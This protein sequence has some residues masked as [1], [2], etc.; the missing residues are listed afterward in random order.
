MVQ[1]LAHEHLHV[2]KVIDPVQGH[3]VVRDRLDQDQLVVRI[4]VERQVIAQVAAHRL[5]RPDHVQGHV[6]D[7]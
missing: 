7:R 2:A 6:Q 1:E 5:M 3:A 4:T